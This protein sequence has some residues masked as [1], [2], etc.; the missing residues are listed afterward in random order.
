MGG[1]AINI[2]HYYGITV[3]INNTNHISITKLQTLFRVH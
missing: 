1:P 3:E 2:S